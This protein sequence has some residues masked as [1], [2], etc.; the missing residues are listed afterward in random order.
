MDGTSAFEARGRVKSILDAADSQDWAALYNSL[1]NCDERVRQTMVEEA[2]NIYAGCAEYQNL[3]AKAGG[4][5]TALKYLQEVTNPSLAV[6][7][8]AIILTAAKE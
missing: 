3:S 1:R 2:G 8:A 4:I 5:K 7:G 6:R